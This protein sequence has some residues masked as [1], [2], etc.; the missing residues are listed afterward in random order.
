MNGL[1]EKMTPVGLLWLRV[2]TGLGIA[3]QHGFGKVFGGNIS[4]FAEGVA[5]L[6]FPF[7]IFFAWMAALTEFLGGILITAGLGTRIAAGFLFINM[8][9]AAFIRHAPDPFGRKELA[10][11]YLMA[12]GAI[13]LLGPG[14]YSLDNLITKWCSRNSS[15]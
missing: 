15:K 5:E 8:A 14:K 3:T 1:K 11:A 12:S 7:A 13:L 2:L 10:F 4:Q 6:G 9:V